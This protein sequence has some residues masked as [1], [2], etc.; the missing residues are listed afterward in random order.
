M[1]TTSN[2]RLE[3]IQGAARS[4][5][6]ARESF[7]HD[8][9]RRLADQ[10]VILSADDL[11]G[12]YDPSRQLFT[13]IDGK[14]RM[15]TFDDILAFKAAVRDIQRKHGQFRAGK[16]TGDA[17]GILARQVIDLSRPEDRQRA[18]KQIHFAT[19]LANRAGVV[20]FQTN[21]GPNSD[22]QRH[23]VTVQFMGYDT[24]L[25]GGLST[26]EAARQMARGKIKFDCDCGRH[27]FWYRY[28][29]TIGNFNVGRA[30]DGFPKV[31]NPKLYGVACKHVLRVM[32]VI[33]HGPTFE[34]F[35]QRMID[36]G[37][38]TLSNKNQTVSV[39]DQQKFVQQALKARKRDRTITTSEERRHARQA[40]P[41]EKRRAAER[42][43]AANDQLRKTHTAK[44][45][46]SVPFEQKI[47]TLM[48]MGYGRDAAVAAI[49]AADQAQR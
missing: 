45:N 25:A 20:Q 16:P 22:T 18:N 34:N 19:P 13:T 6:Q 12:L 32:A 39:A 8:L 37:R 2:T 14:P 9:Q 26:R 29:A 36:N 10:G 5:K 28:I 11:S 17:G 48:A 27:T 24:A 3:F 4:G 35:A 31:R 23:F 44:V 43:K 30:E 1:A 15:L 7:E 49:T 46:K 38:K 40:Q 21:A 33:A 47:K 41:A 42:V